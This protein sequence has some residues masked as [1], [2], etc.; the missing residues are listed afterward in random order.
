[1]SEQEKPL[2]KPPGQAFGRNRSFEG[3]EEGT[4]LMA[5]RLARALA[6]GSVEAFME[7]EMPDNEHARALVSMMMGLTGMMPAEGFTNN[8]SET[9]KRQDMPVIKG[10]PEET[11]QPSPPSEELLKAV[12][13]G[14][15]KGLM[16]ILKNELD[17]R[18]SVGPASSP[19]EHKT[20][21]N[22]GPVIDKEIIDQL[23][24]I[25]S[26]N[27]LTMDWIILRAIRLYVEEYKKTGRL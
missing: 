15:V 13:A 26:E 10:A 4:P 20:D 14:E 25:A 8:P 24:G 22:A 17:E 11:I 21:C 16:G 3:G 9:D 27:S 7:K 6:E 18:S 23:I 2:P 12:T 19:P 1:M 5:D